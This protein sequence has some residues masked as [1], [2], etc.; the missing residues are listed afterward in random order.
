MLHSNKVAILPVENNSQLAKQIDD[1]F[2]KYVCCQFDRLLASAMTGE[3]FGYLLNKIPRCYVLLGI[4]TP[5]EH[6][7]ILR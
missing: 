5:Y 6:F 7:I 2:E 1:Y 4:D 3:D